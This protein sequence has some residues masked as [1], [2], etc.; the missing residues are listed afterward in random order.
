MRQGSTIP[1][2]VRQ[3]PLA[4]S[5]CF[6]VLGIVA[7]M[8]AIANILHVWTFLTLGTSLAVPTVWLSLKVSRGRV[9]QSSLWDVYVPLGIILWVC[10]SLPFHAEHLL[11][12][13]DPATYTVAGIWLTNHSGLHIPKPEI[14]HNLP[15]NSESLGFSTS[16]L[17][18]NELYAQG[19]H[20]LPALLGT[21]GKLF[22]LQAVFSANVVFGGVALLA[23]YGFVRQILRPRWAAFTTLALGVS[24]PF[25]YFTRDTYTEP[26]TLAYIFTALM[27]VHRATRS[28][29]TLRDWIFAGITIG[30]M[31][32]VRPDAYISI[33]ALE[34]FL[35]FRL[36]RSAPAV[37]RHRLH[38]VLCCALPAS[39]LMLFGWIDLTQFSSGYYDDLYTEILTQILLALSLA[40]A[41][42]PGVIL[43]WHTSVRRM[44]DRII[45]NR[46]FRLAVVVSLA[47][48]FSFLL[49]RSA[50]LFARASMGKLDTMSVQ[51]YSSHTTLLWL[52]WYIG[53]VLS[54]GGILK[55]ISTWR[56]VLHG[57]SLVLL[58]L[59]LVLSADCALY[60]LNPRISPD[61]VWASRRFVPVIFPGFILL[62]GLGMQHLYA[63]RGA[64]PWLPRRYKAAIMTTTAAS[65]LTIACTSLPFWSMR[66]FAQEASLHSLCVKLPR[67]ALVV[68]VGDEGDFINESLTALCGSVSVSTT[69]SDTELAA[70]LPQLQDIAK[71]QHRP[72]YIGVNTQ[73]IQLL[74]DNVRPSHTVS[75]AYQEPAHTYKKFSTSTIT[76]RQTV[77]VV[78]VAD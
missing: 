76:S 41:S 50:W 62:G 27:W 28:N 49:A 37:R 56:K 48:F 15:L 26:V 46:A 19:S 59:L 31:A 8:L 36:A 66:P 75:F 24:L 13:R 25:L 69:A 42:I 23:F 11:T 9:Q 73:D 18:P 35:L 63:W 29:G 10:L 57:K 53:P 1:T 39:A 32:L 16:T 17:N 12:D 30:A 77:A 52:I 34:S 51:A 2:W 74:P 22:G 33:A 4:V 68:W 20:L 43:Y 67:T 65:I 60:L 54:L 70:L 40:V 55:F 71:D 6:V 44:I 38:Q 78:R 45:H 64:R 5:S 14:A 7:L 58:P 72:L 21:A 47:V 3:L 61:Q